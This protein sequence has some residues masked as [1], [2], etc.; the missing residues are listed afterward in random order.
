[1]PLYSFTHAETGETKDVYFG[2]NDD[3]I[4]NGEDGTEVGLWKRVWHK[5]NASIDSQIDPYNA[6]DF[7]NKTGAKKG[8]IGNI[9]DASKELS[10][11]RAKDMGV[12]PVQQKHFD[13]Y[14]KTRHGREHP[15][16]RKSKKIDKE[17]FSI[18]FD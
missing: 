11:K 16:E 14:K 10:M 12:D 3:K 7:I 5:P 2:M 1:M 4:F 6:N 13:N 8:T 18:S 9:M 17:G 15:E